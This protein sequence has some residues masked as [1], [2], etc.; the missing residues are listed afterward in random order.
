MCFFQ[1]IELSFSQFQESLTFFIENIKFFI[2]NSNSSMRLSNLRIVKYNI[3]ILSANV[4]IWLCIKVKKCLFF[5]FKEPNF[6]IKAFFIFKIIYFKP[7]NLEII[8]MKGKNIWLFYSSF[9]IIANLDISTIFWSIILK[10]ILIID[11]IND[12]MISTDRTIIKNNH[13]LK[14]STNISRITYFDTT[15]ISLN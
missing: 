3:T 15:F 7:Q 12:C 14:F 9:I 5:Q 6:Q 1:V 13:T 8:V 4:Q 10:I 2:L 11:F